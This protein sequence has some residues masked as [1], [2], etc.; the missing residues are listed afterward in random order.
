VS[1]VFALA[2]WL[3]SSS[4]RAEEAIIKRPGDHP[5]YAFEA[6][7]HLLLGWRELRD[8]PGVGFRGTIPIVHN[9]FVSSINNSV[10]IGFGFDIDPIRHA[11]RFAVPIVMQWNFWLSTHWSVFGEPGASILFGEGH[12]SS[13]VGIPVVHAGGRFHITEAVALTMRVGYPDFSIG[14]SFLL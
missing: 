10:G 13:R 7:P 9:G 3:V 2:V 5:H 8:G 4:V 12:G 14:F 1:F 11:N 6:E